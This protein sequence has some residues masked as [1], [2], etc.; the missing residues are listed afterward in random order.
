MVHYVRTAYIRV[1]IAMVEKMLG[2]RMRC[3]L[4]VIHETDYLH[5]IE[6]VSIIVM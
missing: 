1:H 2:S 5:Q 4:I 3:N 6:L